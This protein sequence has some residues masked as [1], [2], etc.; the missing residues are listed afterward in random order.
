MREVEVLIIGK[1]PAGIQAALYSHRSNVETVVIGKDLGASVKAH[2][3]DNYYGGDGLTGTQL[4]ENGIKQAQGIGIEVI[5]DEVLSLEFTGEDFVVTT[6]TD[7]FKAISV[8]IASGSERQMPRIRRLRNYEGKGVSYCAVCDGFF[9]RNKTIAVIGSKEYAAH[10]AEYLLNVSKDVL[11][12]T[13]GEEIGTE[14]DSRLKIITDKVVEVKGEDRVETLVTTE[15]IFPVDGIFVAVGS[16]SSSDLAIKLGVHVE[17]TKIVV[18]ENMET[19]I[20]GLFAAGDC[21]PGL[22]QIAKA[23]GDGCVAGMNMAHYVRQ[24]KNRR[25]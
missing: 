22:Q 20:P 7:S 24:F 14:F 5:D 8:L 23:V 9:F 3:V 17:N 6:T 15:S 25:K 12:F 2:K 19:N 16:A 10:E 4:V 1:G 18:N 11:L 13:D 21:V